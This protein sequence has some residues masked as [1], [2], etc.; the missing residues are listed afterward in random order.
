MKKIE[1]FF[2]FMTL[3]VDVAMLIASFLVSFLFRGNVQMGLPVFRSDISGYLTLA[4]FYA[5]VAI[6]IFALNGLYNTKISAKNQFEAYKIF[7]SNSVAMSLLVLVLFFSKTFEYSRVI[8]ALTWVLSILFVI[9]GRK[10]IKSIQ[11]YLLKYGIGTRNVILVGSDDLAKFTVREIKINSHLGFRYVGALSHNNKSEEVKIIGNISDYK[12]L[13]EKFRVDEIVFCEYNIPNKTMREVIDYCGDKKISIKY[14][15]AIAPDLALKAISASI[16]SMPML[17]IK[18]TP[19]D[20]WGRIIKRGL[21]IF[22]SIIFLILFTPLIIIISI[23]IK[24]TSKGPLFYTHSR[25]GRDNKIFKFYKFRSMY[26][27]LCDWKEEGKWTTEKDNTT[28]ITPFGRILRKSNLD[29]LPQLWNILKGDMSFVGP[30]PELPKLVEK[31]SF[32][33]PEYLKRHRIKTGLTGWAQVNGLKGDTSVSERIRYDI[34]YVE[35]W[36]VWFDFRIILSTL[37]LMIY[38]LFKGKYE[39]RSGS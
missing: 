39:Y 3:P 13:I 21:D 29:E 32:D 36:S 16:G 10:I 28:R 24:V 15:P 23:L 20:G 4:T 31:F 14:I 5:P 18:T 11:I 34:Y 27:D 25:V 26:D 1:L 8:L 19:L 9:L 7:E 33:N 17:E 37:Y 2:A 6:I 38:E 12:K 35:N 22:F 30:R